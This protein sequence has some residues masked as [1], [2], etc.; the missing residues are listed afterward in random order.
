MDDNVIEEKPENNKAY[1]TKVPRLAENVVTS[2][3]TR[4][5]TIIFGIDENNAVTVIEEPSY[6]SHSH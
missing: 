5:K 6:T 4:P 1:S 3:R 2:F